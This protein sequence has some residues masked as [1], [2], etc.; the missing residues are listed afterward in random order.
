MA[1]AMSKKNQENKSEE[2]ANT[3]NTE[4]SDK[5][6]NGNGRKNKSEKKDNNK[7]KTENTKEPKASDSKTESETNKA[8]GRNR[9][10]NRN[11]KSDN[12]DKEN[13]TENENNTAKKVAHANG[14]AT[15]EKDAD[16]KPMQK[17]QT[18][19]N[20]S[21]NNKNQKFI[22]CKDPQSGEIE[23]VETWFTQSYYGRLINGD[24]SGI[25]SMYTGE[26]KVTYGHEG[27]DDVIENT[28]GGEGSKTK[29]GKSV[30]SEL[31]SFYSKHPTYDIDFSLSNVQKIP[32][33][34]DSRGEK[35]APSVYSLQFIGHIKAAE[36]SD[37]KHF[38]QNF[39]VQWLKDDDQY[40]TILSDTFRYLTKAAVILPGA[41]VSPASKYVQ[42]EGNAVSNVMY[43]AET[44]KFENYAFSADNSIPPPPPADTPPQTNDISSGPPRTPQIIIFCTY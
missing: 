33:F 7:E 17:S 44:G 5:N 15:K 16:S 10:R 30:L 18:E 23:H 39:T 20:S 43:D 37:K 34:I 11:R 28:F 6:A 36:G 24:L 22:Q 42:E 26:S 35:N 25:A 40:L 31:K 14:H 27:N 4:K 3:A 32:I 38:M 41:M 19:P 8:N 13:K 2:R 12:N 29:D 1:A 9:N 21:N